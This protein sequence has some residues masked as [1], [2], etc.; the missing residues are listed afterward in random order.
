[1]GARA[2]LIEIS[3]MLKS[4]EMLKMLGITLK[5]MDFSEGNHLFAGDFRA[6]LNETNTYKEIL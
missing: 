5:N 3:V 6:S 1:M 2:V 4:T